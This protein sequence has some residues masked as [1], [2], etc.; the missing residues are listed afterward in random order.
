MPEFKITINDPKT[1]KSY[2]KALDT[3]IFKRKKIHD[4]IP[5]DE[6]GLKG[7]E[8]E[9]SGGSDTAGFPMRKDLSGTAKK[10]LLL[11]GG[12]G[13]KIKRRGARIRKT[14]R[15][16][17]IGLHTAQINLKIIKYGSKK[18]EDAL[19]SAEK[20]EEA[21]KEEAKPEEKPKE[22]KAED[23]PKEEKKEEKVEEKKEEK[24]KEEK[25]EVKKEEKA[26]DKKE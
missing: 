20:K 18:L 23:K 4:K 16:N 7:Y 3:N 6:L 11:T 1:G 2:N 26:E 24:P 12:V 8:L 22:K 13:V 9:I 10:K 25:P 19:G 5:G 14:I 17:E 15:G 21:P